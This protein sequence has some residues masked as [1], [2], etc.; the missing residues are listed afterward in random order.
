MDV[1]F[2]VDNSRTFTHIWIMMVNF[3]ETLVGMLNIS[4]EG[5]RVGLVE[6]GEL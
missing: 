5:T 1:A 3:L 4:P 2:V 6:F